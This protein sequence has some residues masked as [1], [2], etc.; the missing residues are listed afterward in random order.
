MSRASR[1]KV[2]VEVEGDAGIWSLYKEDFKTVPEAEQ[3]VRENISFGDV[4]R[5]A[6]IS[7]IFRKTAEVVKR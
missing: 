7:G 3:W 4:M 5:V 6:K 1:S 2:V